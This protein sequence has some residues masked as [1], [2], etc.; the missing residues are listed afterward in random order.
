MPYQNPTAAMPAMTAD[1]MTTEMMATHATDTV[2]PAVV[3]ADAWAVIPANDNTATDMAPLVEPTDAMMTANTHMAP[4]MAMPITPTM[5]TRY[6][7]SCV[8]FGP[9]LSRRA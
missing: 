4:D 9:G 6:E 1:V 2:A 3:D 5:R 7:R 8:N